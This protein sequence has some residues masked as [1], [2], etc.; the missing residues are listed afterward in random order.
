MRLAPRPIGIER[1]AAPVAADWLFRHQQASGVRPGPGASAVAL[2]L[3]SWSLLPTSE[4]HREEPC[5]GKRCCGEPARGSC[6]SPAHLDGILPQEAFQQS[7]NFGLEVCRDVRKVQL[8]LAVLADDIEA[9]PIR[10]RML[11]Q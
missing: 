5:I 7:L 4:R 8:N 2:S 10:S 1:G 11:L 3:L 6:L 9:E